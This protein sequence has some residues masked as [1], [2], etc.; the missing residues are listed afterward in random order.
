MKFCVDC[1]VI[2]YNKWIFFIEYD[3]IEYIMLLFFIFIK[4]DYIIVEVSYR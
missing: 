3:L 2:E 1:T 4:K